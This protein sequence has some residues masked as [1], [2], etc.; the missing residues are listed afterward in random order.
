[1]KTA[2]LASNLKK[3][4][5]ENNEDDICNFNSFA[6]D[7]SERNNDQNTPIKSK[8]KSKKRK[9]SHSRVSTK[10][11]QS[12]NVS[13]ANGLSNQN[14]IMS[15]LVDSLKEKI[16]IYE[17]EMRNLIDEKV[18]MQLM[19]NNLQLNN[20]KELRKSKAKSDCKTSNSIENVMQSQESAI[21]LNKQYIQEVSGLKKE[22][23]NLN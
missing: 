12:L 21:E 2:K 14:Q 5:E 20:Y 18:Q 9:N 22:L 11:S 1:M 8:S 17:N 4:F 3:N 13:N 15:D 7:K 23:K 16:L 19:I 6:S 10:E